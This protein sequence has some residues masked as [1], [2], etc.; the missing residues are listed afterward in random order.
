[1]FTLE[2][3]GEVQRQENRVMGLLRIKGCVILTSTV[4]DLS[5]RV[6]DG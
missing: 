6:T 4:F 5:T 1:M 3:H 2:F